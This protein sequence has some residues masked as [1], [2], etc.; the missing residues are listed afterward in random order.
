MPFLL[1]KPSTSPTGKALAKLLDIPCGTTEALPAE[2]VDTLVR[3]GNA[4][5][6]R[7]RPEKVL[8]Q[9]T[10]IIASSDKLQSLELLKRGGV[11]VPNAHPL[12]HDSIKLF[13]YPALARTR[14]HT[15]GRDIALCLQPHD[16]LQA[17][18]KGCEYLVE[19]VQTEAE[20]RLH[21]C[22]GSVIKTSQKV[23]TKQEDAIPWIRNHEH[24]YTFRKVR[25]TPSEIVRNM[26]V[27]AVNLVGL[28]FG[29]VDVLISTN[30]VPWILEINTAPGLVES[31]L[32]T[33]AKRFAELLGKELTDFTE[34]EEGED[35][36]V[37]KTEEENVT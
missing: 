23:L 22:N 8:N 35:D 10:A 3:W 5:R 7:L 29:A 6:T 30:G 37:E 34:V 31:G 27:A 26:C 2:R 17:L 9:R 32:K 20:Y 19:Y 33:Y 1:Y 25:T 16:A 15:R 24:G 28:D 13:A 36:E 4:D 14:R 12:N 21:V 18:E 11:R